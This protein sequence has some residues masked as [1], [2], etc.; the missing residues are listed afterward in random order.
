MIEELVKKIKWL[1]LDSGLTTYEIGKATGQTTQFLDRYKN[2]PDKILGMSMRKA[3]ILEEYIQ[4]I[5]KQ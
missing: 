3:Q 1:L 2:D 4:K 5:Q